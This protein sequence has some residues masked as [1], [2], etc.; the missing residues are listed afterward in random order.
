MLHRS[1][2]R[3]SQILT[4]IGLLVVCTTLTAAELKT[5]NVNTVKLSEL[6]KPETKSYPATVVSENTAKISAKINAEITSLPLRVGDKVSQGQTVA[7]LDCDLFELEVETTKAALDLAAED[8]GRIKALKDKNVVSA[9]QYTAAS[10][11]RRQA[12]VMYKRAQLQTRYCTVNAPFAGVITNRL[13]SLGD[14]AAAGMPLI[15]LVQTD[16]TEVKVLLPVDVANSLSAEQATFFKQGATEHPITLRTVL[17]VI[18]QNT[19]TQEARFSTAT[20]LAPGAFG[21]LVWSSAANLLPPDML[22][23]RKGK[24]GVFIVRDNLA[25]FHEIEGAVAGKPVNPNLPNSTLVITA[26]RHA[27]VHGQPVKIQ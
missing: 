24:L 23:L 27:L 4:P 5:V 20:A 13:A 3:L 17:P 2:K 7:Q 21:R 11:S 19:K 6:V 9:Q 8:L 22:Q 18:D 14:F 25:V 26:G 10:V 16:N 15:E 12:S 1:F